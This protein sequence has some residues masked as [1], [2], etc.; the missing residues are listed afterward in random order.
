MLPK[1]ELSGK[2]R[3]HLNNALHSGG[4]HRHKAWVL[5]QALNAAK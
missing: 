4:G 1:G 5:Y 2:Q 3:E